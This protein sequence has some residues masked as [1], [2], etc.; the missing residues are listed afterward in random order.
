MRSFTS[1][2]K[3]LAIFVALLISL[4]ACIGYC[5]SEFLPKVADSDLSYG[6]DG[7]R[8][9]I[10]AEQNASSDVLS[11]LSTTDAKAFSQIG[12]PLFLAAIYG[13]TIP[14]PFV[15]VATN[16]C[17]WI[18]AGFLL[19][20]ALKGYLSPKYHFVFNIL[21]ILYPES[22]SWCGFVMKEALVVFLLS[23]AVALCCA[24]TWKLA[25]SAGVG[26]LIPVTMPIRS[27]AV[28]MMGLAVIIAITFRRREAQQ[29]LPKAVL[30]ATALTLAVYI[31]SS[32]EQSIGAPPGI[33]ELSQPVNPLLLAGYSRTESAFSAGLSNQSVLMRM[34]SSN[35]VIDSLYIPIRGAAN[36]LFPLYL[37]PLDSESLGGTTFWLQWAS[38]CCCSVCSLA[39]LLS[40]LERRSWTCPRT[41]LFGVF[42]LGFIALG[43]SGIV[44]ERYRSL[45]V[46]VLL[47]LGIK[48]LEEEVEKHGYRRFLVWC[49]SF[50]VAL[51][52]YKTIRLV[53]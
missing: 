14:H 36:I 42:V 27:T 10:F 5:Q 16:W 8:Y 43:L 51:L 23:S 28:P 2:S 15:A 33:E 4:V 50:P 22:V 32:P 44:H 24:D 21:W 25:Q 7:L 18:A 39:I 12:Y 40:V 48:S 34:G 17:L 3:R 38:A 1:P 11:I 47:P 20:K 26:L 53:L 52:V 30:L 31:G 41:V 19:S 35:R 45:L 37:N 9:H 46:P 29:G 49:A 6:H 13:M